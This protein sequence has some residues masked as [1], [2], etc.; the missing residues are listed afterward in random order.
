M[1]DL[2]IAGCK[3]LGIYFLFSFLLQTLSV[4]TTILAQDNL[5][6]FF[7]DSYIFYYLGEFFLS[8]FFMILLLFGSNFLANTF[9]MKNSI[10]FKINISGRQLLKVGILIIGV[11]SVYGS[12]Y[13][14]YDMLVGISGYFARGFTYEALE[15]VIKLWIALVPFY[16]IFQVDRV[17][18][19]LYK[20]K[21]TEDEK[22]V[23]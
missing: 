11:F 9:K 6:E 17:V 14:I 15:F 22:T 3:V 21:E 5:S 16:F 18:D 12:L 23:E 19:F 13:R 20:E 2:F 1:R 8:L 10:D 4:T 7:K